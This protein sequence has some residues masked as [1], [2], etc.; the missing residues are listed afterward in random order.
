[1]KMGDGKA[2]SCELT[3]YED[4]EKYLPHFL[5]LGLPFQE[6]LNMAVGK[7]Y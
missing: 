4:Y 7:C 2:H 1:M 3:L 6:T 5:S